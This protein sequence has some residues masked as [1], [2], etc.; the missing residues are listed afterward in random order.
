MGSPIYDLTS[1]SLNAPSGNTTKSG[2]R[3][4]NE[5]NRYRVGLTYFDTNFGLIQIDWTEADPLLRLQVYDEQGG[6]VLQQR[7]RLSELRAP[8]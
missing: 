3:F 2:T 5:I 4:A 8:M 6:V 1:S 7:V